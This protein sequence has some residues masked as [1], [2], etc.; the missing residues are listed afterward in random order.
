[1]NIAFAFTGAGH[2]LKESVEI[3]EKL[4]QEHKVSVFLSNASC[5]VLKMYGLY[6]RVEKRK[7]YRF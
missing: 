4:S 1:M 2:L 3:Y 7:K 5:E 6:E